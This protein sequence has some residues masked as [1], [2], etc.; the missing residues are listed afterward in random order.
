M[1]NVPEAVPEFVTHH[2]EASHIAD[3]APMTTRGTRGEA[4]PNYSRVFMRFHAFC[5]SPRLVRLV[6]Q[7]LLLVYAQSPI[8]APLRI[9]RIPRLNCGEL[10]NQA[11]GLSLDSAQCLP[12]QPR[13]RKQLC[14]NTLTS[15]ERSKQ[16]ASSRAVPR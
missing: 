15:I 8:P 5:D 7:S 11:R 9:R 6:R 3:L 2:K 4:S 13:I 16:Y 10:P 12:L 1:V 14:E